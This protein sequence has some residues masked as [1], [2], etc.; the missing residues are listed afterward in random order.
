MEVAAW[1]RMYSKL[2]AKR[3]QSVQGRAGEMTRELGETSGG[4]EGLWKTRSDDRGVFRFRR[5]LCSAA[6]VFAVATTVCAADVDYP[7]RFQAAN[8]NDRNQA[9]AILQEWKAARASDPEYYIAAANFVLSK[10]SGVIIS[11]KKAGPDDLVIAAEKSGREVGSISSSGPS[12]AGYQTAIEL[13]KE[14]ISKAPA[15][16]DI[17]LGLATL[18]KDSGAPGELV[19]DLSALAAYAN[20]HPGTLLCKDGK[21]YPEP[22]RENLSHAISNFARDY[23]QL[24][25]KE[26]DK[27]FHRLAELDVTAFPDCEY[28]YNLM[29][30]YY[31]TIDRNPRLAL[32]NYEKCLKLVPNDSLVWINIGVVRRM[33]GKTRE[34]A[35]AFKKVIALNNDP[36]CVKQAEAELAKLK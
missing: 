23:F 28:G 1:R 30:V 25:T 12:A 27:T 3:L 32:E 7:G 31:S 14:G 29:G 22:A 11:T 18:H 36:G 21:S 17:Y 9:E 34:A 26:G 16:I 19:K 13:L 35:E 24:E 20:E 10:E 2:F 33:A 4:C 8:R 5:F 6:Q 15:R